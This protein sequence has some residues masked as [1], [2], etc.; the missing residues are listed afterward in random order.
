MELK[1]DLGDYMINIIELDGEARN[2]KSLTREFVLV[3]GFAPCIE[4][5]I[6][7]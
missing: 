1:L 7:K 3:G 2:L 4:V 5:L 6:D